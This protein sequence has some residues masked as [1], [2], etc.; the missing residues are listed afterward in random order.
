MMGLKDNKLTSLEIN[1]DPL[2]LTKVSFNSI[3]RPIFE[4]WEGGGDNPFKTVELDYE[5][6]RYIHVRLNNKIGHFEN[7]KKIVTNNYYPV[8][9]CKKEWFLKTEFERGFFD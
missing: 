9:R 2:D 6:R 5:S 7:G 4:I 1:T 3:S 8:E